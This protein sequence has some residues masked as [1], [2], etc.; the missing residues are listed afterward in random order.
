MAQI[1][2]ANVA[3]AWVETP[4][5]GSS[6]IFVDSASKKVSVKDDAGNVWVIATESYV[7][8]AIPAASNAEVIAGTIENKYVNPKTLKDNYEKKYDVVVFTRDAWW[9]NASVVYNHWLWVAPK[10]I[11]FNF[12]LHENSTYLTNWSWTRDWTENKCS[13]TWYVFTRFA[14]TDTSHCVVF[15]A[16]GW[17]DTQKWAVSAVSATTFTIDWTYVATVTWTWCITATLFA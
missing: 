11:I 7:T 10:C 1:K 3:T 4:V 2:I 15:A 5:S 12:T 13:Y 8:S 17:A 6:T 9:A 14:T 16:D